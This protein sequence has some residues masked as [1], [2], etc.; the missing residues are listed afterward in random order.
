MFIVLNCIWWNLWTEILGQ[1]SCLPCFSILFYL[2]F[3]SFCS[4]LSLTRCCLF[5][6][7]VIVNKDYFMECSEC[8][9]NVWIFV[10]QH[11]YSIPI[12]VLATVSQFILFPPRLPEDTLMSPVDICILLQDF[13]NEMKKNKNTCRKMNNNLKCK[14]LKNVFK[15]SNTWPHYQSILTFLWFL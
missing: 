6:E 5:V 8:F 15:S 3:A 13:R 4:S 1:F 2:N 10:S 14:M 12:P 7:N 11:Y 9:R